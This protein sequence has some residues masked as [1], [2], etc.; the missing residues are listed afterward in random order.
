MQFGGNADPNASRELFETA[1]A[2]SLN[3]FDTAH[4]YNGGDAERLLGA[5][6]RQDRDSLMIA[7]K[8]AY[9]GGSSRATI[10]KQFE[11]SRVRLGLDVVDILYLHRWDHETPLEETF[12]TLAKLQNDGK[13]RHIGASNFAAWQVMKAQAV[14]VSMGTRIDV[15]QPMY[16]LVK[17]QAEVE[18]LPMAA[19]E[20]IAVAPYSPLGSGLLTGKYLAGGTGRLSTDKRYAARY[21]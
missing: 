11:E 3:F 13:I 19:A 21:G 14:A 8:V 18:I 7:T 16:S 10:L 9:T 1:R 5:F 4:V 6:A 12:E 2:A 15:L 17:R 20:R